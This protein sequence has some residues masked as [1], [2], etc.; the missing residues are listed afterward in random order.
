M[1]GVLAKRRALEHAVIGEAIYPVLEL[2]RVDVQRVT[3]IQLAD[4]LAVLGAS[5]NRR[6]G[7]SSGTLR[8]RGRRRFFSDYTR[9]LEPR[10]VLPAIAQHFGENR[11]AVLAQFRRMA[12][13][14]CRRL[15]EPDRKAD[16]LHRAQPGM[17]VIDNIFVGSTCASS[18]R[19][20]TRLT[21]V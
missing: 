19:S 8:A 16:Q 12:A 21:T 14:I 1:P 15:A 5:C 2:A 6:H 11:L 4:L 9:F 10:H 18:G 17:L 7:S 20:E 13:R 3:R